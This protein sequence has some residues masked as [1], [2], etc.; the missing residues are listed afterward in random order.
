M[1]WEQLIQYASISDVGFRRQNNQDAC[2]VRVCIDQ[3]QWTTHGHLFLVA[4]GMGGHA[5]GELAS[6]IA[7]DTVPHTFYKFK[8][9][10]AGEALQH[11]IDVA[12]AAI[13]KRGMLNR[14]F[15]RMGTTC[16][17][18]VLGPD[19]AVIGHVGDSR[20]YR[21]RNE[22]I[23]QLTFDHSLQWELIRQGRMKAEDVFLHQPRNVITRSLG[24]EPDVA[25]DVEGPYPILPRDVYLLCSDGLTGHVSDEEIGMAAGHLPPGEACRFLTHLANLRGGSDNITVVIARVADLPENGSDYDVPRIEPE[26]SGVRSG[27]LVAFWAIAAGLVIG[28]L[29]QTLGRPTL[30]AALSAAAV[31]LATALLAWWWKTRPPAPVPSDEQDTRLSHLYR[32]AACRLKP[33]FVH[34]LATLESDLKRTAD[35]EGWKI[36]R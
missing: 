5:V 17:A 26:S 13:Y 1:R 12:N 3:T 27:W 25:I 9:R 20:V 24:P 36:D 7:V 19:G 14:E 11:A 34:Q 4:D 21:I 33:E 31:L 18:L 2:T 32:T 23:D 28:I 30:G 10:D 6:K 35:E 16:S 8:G 22:Q 15:N 29:L